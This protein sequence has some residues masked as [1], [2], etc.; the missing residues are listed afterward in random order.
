MYNLFRYNIYIYLEMI[1]FNHIEELFLFQLVENSLHVGPT[2][3]IFDGLGKTSLDFLVPQSGWF[4]VIPWPWRCF[5]TNWRHLDS[6]ASYK[7]R[8]HSLYMFE[9]PML[10]NQAKANHLF[11]CK[12]KQ[13]VAIDLPSIWDPNDG[14]LFFPHSC[15]RKYL[16][17]S[18]HIFFLCL[19]D[20]KMTGNHMTAM[21]A[22]QTCVNGLVLPYYMY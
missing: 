5:N 7:P 2:K 19:A 21:I 6:M 13:C 12:K 8:Q 18:C 17:R 4:G 16:S 22:S 10:Q 14:S 9:L 1:K 3:I 20:C 15:G 11:S